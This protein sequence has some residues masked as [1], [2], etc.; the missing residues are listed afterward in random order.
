M[1]TPNNDKAAVEAATQAWID[2]FNE[3]DTEVIST[4]YDAGAVLWGT[5]SPEIILSAE[6][7]RAY[8]ARTFQITP[9]P[10]V[11]LA[12]HDVA[13]SGRD[14][15][16][17][18]IATRNVPGAMVELLTPLA[19]HQVSMAKLESRPSRMGM[20][21]YVFF[22][23]IEGHHQDVSVASALAELQQK[24]SWLKVLGS[25]PVAVI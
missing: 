3:H 21:E 15:T 8:F 25:Y 10:T 5:L 17:L 1:T 20:W 24:S 12:T 16:S 23:D 7:V 9:P 11:V 14:K 6:G 18:V 4:L 22:V 19:E 13:P 2:A